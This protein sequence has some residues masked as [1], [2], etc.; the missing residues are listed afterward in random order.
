M[1]SIQTLSVQLLRNS[2]YFELMTDL[3]SLMVGVLPANPKTDEL[4]NQFDA[5]YGEMDEA[6]RVDM[7]SILTEKI[8]V[9]DDLRG[10]TWKAMNLCIDAHLNSPNAAEMESAKVVRRIFDVYGDYR[11]LSYD[12]ESNNGR[13]LIQD[14]EKPENTNHVKRVKLT[15]WVGAYKEQLQEF[16][17]LQNDRDSEATLKVS[18]NVRAIREKMDPLYRDLINMVNAYVAI[19]LATPEIETFIAQFNQKIKRYNTTLAA[20]Q[21]RKNGKGDSVELPE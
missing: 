14:L 11:K 17:T 13:N 5:V 3:K 2:V 19:G 7:G 12:A 21:G 15:S 16:K 1:N 6:M 10:T 9:A 20:S 4:L 18:G 8:R